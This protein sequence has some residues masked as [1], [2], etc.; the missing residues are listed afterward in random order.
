MTFP[1]RSANLAA[2][3]DVPSGRSAYPGDSRGERGTRVLRS[4]VGCAPPMSWERAVRTVDERT[5]RQLATGYHSTRRRTIQ[6]VR[7]RT[8]L[9][10]A[11]GRDA[12]T[13]ALAVTSGATDAIGYLLLGHVFTSAMTGNLVLLGISLG[14]RNGVRAGRV[15]V[16]LASFTVGC[17]VGARIAG[18]A[19]ANDSVWPTAVTRALVLE[20]G[21]FVCYATEWW[22]SGGHPSVAAKTALLGTG[23]V[24]LGIQSATMQRFGVTGLNTTFLSGALMRFVSGLAT[25][26]RFRD[27][28]HQLLLLV[29]L[30]TGGAITALVVLHS[31]EFV[32]IVQ[33]APLSVALV[34]AAIV[35]RSA[36]HAVSSA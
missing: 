3:T 31:P 18:E 28:A 5:V 20:S 7:Q 21:L 36:R 30:V 23:A 34:L 11:R 14:H 8:N 33:L 4:R 9:A 32:P 35:N 6:M 10:P 12:A 13:V 26:E 2:M 29:G 27:V 25:G 1:S 16:S 17:A 15:I 22:T 24:A 19:R